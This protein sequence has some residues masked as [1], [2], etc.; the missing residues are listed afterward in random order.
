MPQTYKLH[1]D[2]DS[3]GW[4]DLREDSELLELVRIDAKRFLQNPRVG[5]R[6]VIKR[7]VNGYHLE[8]PFAELTREEQDLMT[9]ESHC[10]TGYRW[11]TLRHGRATLRI[12]EKSI[13]KRIGDRF[14]GSRRER[15]TPQVI[16]VM[17]IS[18]R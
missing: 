4:P 5:G 12:G 7:T 15:E 2:Y 13:V 3:Y 18:R 11:W 9:L 14:V 8:A 6:I 17:K 16:E 1:L 10:D